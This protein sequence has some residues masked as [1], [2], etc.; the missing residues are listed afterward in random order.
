M[1][2]CKTNIW[3]TGKP[4]TFYLDLLVALV[5]TGLSYKIIISLINNIFQIA[6]EKY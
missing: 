1:Y 3:M 6:F 4:F 2:H 5:L